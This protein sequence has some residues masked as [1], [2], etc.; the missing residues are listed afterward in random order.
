MIFGIPGNDRD[1]QNAGAPT[2]GGLKNAMNFLHS[3]VTGC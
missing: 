3:G 1:I 2:G